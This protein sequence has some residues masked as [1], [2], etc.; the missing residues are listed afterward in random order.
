MTVFAMPTPPALRDNCQ[1][2]TCELTYRCAAY[3]NPKL[4]AAIMLIFRRSSMFSLQT[5]KVGTTDKAKSCANNG[6]ASSSTPEARV[7]STYHKS[8]VSTWKYAVCFHGF[9]RDA[10][11]P[12]CQKR[13][14]HHIITTLEERDDGDADGGRRAGGDQEPHGDLLPPLNNEAKEGD[15]KGDLWHCGAK[16]TK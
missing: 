8:L 7:G 16:N 15:A 10:V 1:R 2:W 4:M 11:S 6:S 5:T 9:L 13:I 14:R 12:L 3:M